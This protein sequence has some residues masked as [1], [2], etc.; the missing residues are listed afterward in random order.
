MTRY[1]GKYRGTV[2]NHI[3]PLQQ[4][5]I[6]V[7]VPD[8]TLPPSTWAMPCFPLAGIQS[9]MF[10]VPLPGTGVWVEFE[11]GDSDHPIWTGCW[12]GSKA[13]I[14]ALVSAAPPPTPPIVLQ[15]PGQATVMVSD[16]PGPAGGILL[17]TLTGAMISINDTGIV[18]S[19]GKGASITLVGPTVA[20]NQT[21]LTVT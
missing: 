8:V 3:D 5:R 20:V 10:A 13:E 2:V 4:G 11:Q 1:Y 7:T 17:K 6:Q 15:T 21:A 18:I 9:G 12:Y 16:A 19:N 14:P